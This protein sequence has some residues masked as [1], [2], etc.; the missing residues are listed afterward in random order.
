MNTNNNQRILRGQTLAFVGN[1]FEVGA[2]HAFDHCDDGAVLIEKG[3]VVAVG[4]AGEIIENNKTAPIVD[5]GDGLIMAGF[6]DAH[7]HFPQSDIIGSYNDGL[8]DWLTRHTFPAEMR[9]SD[10]QI[11]KRKAELFLDQC[12]L[13]GVTTAGVYCT[14]HAQSVDA[15]FQAASQKNVLMAAGKVCMDKNAPEALMD[16]AQS[17]YDDT[18]ALIEKWHGAGRNRYIITPR[19]ALTSSSQQLKAL[20]VLWKEHPTT[21]MQTHLSETKDEIAEVLKLFPAHKSYYDVYESFGLTG[22]GAI[23]GHCIHLSDDE[24][25]MIATSGGA[26]A[27]CP[28]SN[29]FIGSGHFDLAET[30]RAAPEIKLSL[31]SDVGG[32]T[33]FSMFA[34]MKGAY[35]AARAN[36]SMLHP[37]E[38]FWLATIG[39]AKVL[40][41]DDKIG[42]LAAGMDAD[43]VVIDLKSTPLISARVKRAETLADVLFAQMIMADERAV[44]AT[45]IAG[46]LL[47]DRSTGL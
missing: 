36:G 18:K 28:T 21:L 43:L 5:Y 25:Q 45:Y 9:F 29:A 17:A 24:R 22:E 14:V 10:P 19:F 38:A 42:N 12:F 26:I 7:T 33:S 31:G 20:G 44:K 27:H 35:E 11:G 1:P 30:R 3:R 6:V 4:Q 40:R 23:F 34:T 46:E 32:G 13:N 41:L 37:A 16:T 47:Y 15:F 39:G 8:L 2:D